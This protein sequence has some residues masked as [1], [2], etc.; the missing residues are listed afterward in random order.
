MRDTNYI[1]QWRLQKGMTAADLAR[2]IRVDRSQIHLLENS[3]RRLTVEA[4]RDIADAL[5]ISV[6]DLLSPPPNFTAAAGKFVRPESSTAYT[7]G[8]KAIIG[9]VKLQVEMPWK[10]VM[11]ETDEME[12]TFRKGDYV[13]VNTEETVVSNGVFVINASKKPEIRRLQRTGNQVR[14]SCD[15]TQYA[16]VEAPSTKLTDVM[17]VA[18]HLRNI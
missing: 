17:R 3:K 18:I 4:M 14:V 16:P 11:V 12:P 13:V 10:L 7:K 1:K 9:G 15:N 6:E 2:A 5:V 8:H